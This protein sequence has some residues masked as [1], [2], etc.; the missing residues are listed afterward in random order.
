MF[1]PLR[2]TFNRFMAEPA[3]VRNAGWLIM[4]VT[5]AATIAGSIVVWL[6]DKRDFSTYG[7]ALWYSLQTV[8]TV[9]YG[10]VTPES[11]LGRVV[12]GIV[13]VVAIAFLTIVTAAITSAFW[14]ASQ[15]A[16]R[17]DERARLA[18]D[19]EHL[20]AALAAIGTRLDRIEQALA[21]DGRAPDKRDGNG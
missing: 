5:F 19:S 13:M 3:S 10:D 1:R 20:A 2:R 8:T 17:E 6:F 4:G 15:R 18:A 9:G 11:A 12:G 16:R 14:D 7:D 21:R